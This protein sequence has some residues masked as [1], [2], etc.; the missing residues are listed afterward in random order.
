M[1]GSQFDDVLTGSPRTVQLEGFDGD[2]RITGGSGAEA[3]SGG[4]GN[5]RID[6]RDGAPD[7]IDCGGQALDWAVVDGAEAFVTRCAAITEVDR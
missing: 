7:R 1:F 3:L 5:D 2:D 4:D 6:A